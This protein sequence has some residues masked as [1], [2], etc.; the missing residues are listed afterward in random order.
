[1]SRL[2]NM[3]II[4]TDRA[5]F[6]RWRWIRGPWVGEKVLGGIAGAVAVAGAGYLL[7]EEWLKHHGK[8]HSEAA[9]AEFRGNVKPGWESHPDFVSKGAKLQ[10]HGVR[11]SRLRKLADGDFNSPF[12]PRS[13]EYSIAQQDKDVKDTTST[14]RTNANSRSPDK[15]L[16]VKMVNF[17][18]DQVRALMNK[19]QN[20]RNISVIAHVDHGKSTLTDHL[21]QR[22]GLISAAQAGGALFTDGREDEK[23]RGITIKSTAVTMAFDVDPSVVKDIT[24][25]GVDGD[26]F[27]VNLID[28]P[29]HVDFSS[30]VTAALRVT[31]G[32]LV[33][34]DAVDG[35]CVQTETVLRQALTERIR[36]AMI[37]NKVDRALL[38]LQVDKESLYQSFLRTVE[39]VNVVIATYA[40]NQLANV[41]MDPSLGNVA[42]GAGLHGWAFTLRQFA[43]R[44]SEKF[45]VSKEKLMERLWGD[46]YFNPRT[47]KWTTSAVDP[48]TGAT[49]ERGF[50]M[51]VLEPIY[52]LFDLTFTNP[53]P[54][55]L[56]SVL[57][58]LRIRL[59]SGE[60]ALTG[61]DLL[62]AVMR[63]FLPAADAM[64]ELVCIHLPSPVAAQAYRAEMLYEGPM[65]DACAQAI[66]ACDPEGPLMVYVSKMVPSNAGRFYALGRVFSGVVRPGQ[67]VR[68]MGPNFVFGRKDDLAIKPVQRTVVM[69]GG[70]VSSVEGCPAG[71][72]V[73][74]VGIDQYLVKSGTITTSESAHALRVMNFSVSPVVQVAVDVVHGA[75]LPKLIEGLRR[76]AKSDPCVKCYTSDSGEHIV[77]GAG[78]LHVEVCLNDLEK[79]L[80]RVPLKRGDPI[81]PYRETVTTESTVLALAKSPNRHNRIFMRAEPLGE[82]L[83]A[84]IERGALGRVGARADPK[85][86]ARA[87][88]EDH[89]WDVSDARRIWCFGPDTTG[90]NVLVDTTRAVAYIQDARD[91]CGAAF[92]WATKEGPLADEP[93]RGV[94]FNLVDMVLHRDAVHRGGGQVMPTCRRAMHASVLSG[95]PTLQEPVYLVECRA[96]ESA[97]GGVYACL[98]MRRGRVIGEEVDAR[99]TMRTIRAY[100]PVAESFG[101]SGALREATGGQAFPQCVFDHWGVMEGFGSPLT[102]GSRAEGVVQGVRKRKGLPVAI[103][104]I[105]NFL[106]RM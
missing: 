99:G 101:F 81:V 46:H 22:A 89:G 37:I 75:D 25:P 35:V 83:T 6:H 18:T 2:L 102:K 92:Q 36:P 65:D 77:A 26:D 4:I 72:V 30:E 76:L 13:E 86:R 73:G 82:D 3:I 5:V 91:S 20:V 47:R 17:T 57:D 7:Y 97:V 42:F 52:R 100:L 43:Q 11:W 85:D 12:C 68:I 39:T 10:G 33:V 21:V 16:Q 19:R 44:Y 88:A 78:E 79:E 27:L 60:L 90:A 58:Q 50:N 28:S 80:A 96:P 38:E 98:S 62:K 24:E 8:E 29:G 45:G 61:K 53:N 87:L 40:D 104:D 9:A 95:A 32:A 71:C 69:M 34:V 23:E 1:M 106:D 14:A 56:P 48:S 105:S 64:L 66:R 51:F 94:R 70:K 41:R 103:P 93:V 59:K 49:L 15:K 84:E 55:K 54:D 63:A 67:Q 74:L 31:D